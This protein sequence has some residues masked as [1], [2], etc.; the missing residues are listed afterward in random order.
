MSD[1]PGGQG[2]YFDLWFTTRESKNAPWRE[3][4]NL[5]PA[6]NSGLDENHPHITSD[7]LI[8]FFES[9]RGGGLGS[10]DFW[11]TRR[12]DTTSAWEPPVNLG[13]VI[14]TSGQ[15][16]SSCVSYDNKTFYFGRVSI[17]DLWQAPIL[18]VVDFNRDN[19]V[20]MLDLSILADTVE[21]T[22]G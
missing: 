16:W 14:N 1:R 13:P 22:S 21:M 18:P 6:V 9:N 8:L 17:G 11:M 19:V 5:G 3:P 10:Y 20:N 2:N 4:Q 7:G 15:E 12:Q